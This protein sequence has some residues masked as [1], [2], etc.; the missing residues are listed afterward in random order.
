[1]AS[2]ILRRNSLMGGKSSSLFLPISLTESCQDPICFLSSQRFKCGPSEYLTP[3]AAN[4]LPTDQVIQVRADQLVWRR[5][6]GGEEG[7]ISYT[8]VHRCPLLPRIPC[9]DQR[10]QRGRSFFTFVSRPFDLRLLAKSPMSLHHLSCRV[11]NPHRARGIPRTMS[12]LA[13]SSPSHP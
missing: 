2:K 6:P 9:R 3:L 11:S 7:A 1:M 8:F 5:S 4:Y 13:S 12:R 10:T